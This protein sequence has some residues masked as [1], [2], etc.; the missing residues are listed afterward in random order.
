MLI[1]EISNWKASEER[2]VRLEGFASIGRLTVNLLH[3]LNSPLDGTR[4]YVR[5]LLDQM[6]DDD[7]NS[8]YVGQIQKGLTQISDM[9]DRLMD[10]TRA[11][12]SESARTDIKQSID[13][14]IFSHKQLIIA[15][16]IEVVTEF[17]EYIPAVLDSNVEYIF[18]NIMVN[19]IQAMPDGGTLSIAAKMCS[20]RLLEVVFTDTGAGIPDEIQGNIFDPFFTTKG[21][22]HGIGLG[23]F[24]SREMLESY[25]GEIEVRSELGKGATFIV[26][27][28]MYKGKILVMDD[29][30]HMR[31]TISEMLFKTG[32]KV[33]SAIDGS[34]AVEMYKDANNLGRPYDAIILD[35]TVPGGMNGKEAIR[36]L[37]EIDPEVRAIVSSGYVMSDFGKYGFKGALCKPYDSKELDKLLD[38]VITD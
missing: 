33:T 20:P 27:L 10:F 18:A 16:N 25:G 19:A 17:D 6:S 12:S 32:Y 13:R 8:I 9:V 30:K 23:L 26:N 35:L 3:E 14:I 31:D 5:L 11:N 1:K 22:G 29:E 28:P 38:A 2:L 21:L 24:M 15:Q 37:L 36:E 7:P 4:R 34:E